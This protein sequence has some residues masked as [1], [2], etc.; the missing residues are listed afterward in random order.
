MPQNFWWVV[1]AWVLIL[2]GIFVYGFTQI[3]RQ[4]R[5]ARELARERASR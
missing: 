2:G 4:K 5:L 3:N 1:A